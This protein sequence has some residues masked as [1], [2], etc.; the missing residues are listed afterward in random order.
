MSSKSIKLL[1]EIYLRA[2]TTFSRNHSR[3]RT[4]RN[5]HIMNKQKQ[6]PRLENKKK[7]SLNKQKTK[8]QSKKNFRKKTQFLKKKVLFLLESLNF[9]VCA[10]AQN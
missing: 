4:N 9:S 3:N 8:K 2:T 5:N 7:N 1:L 6:T 10:F